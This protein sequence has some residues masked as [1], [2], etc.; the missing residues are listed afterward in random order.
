MVKE[1]LP[2]LME[3]SMRES[4]KMVTDTDREPSLHLKEISMKG[5]SG[6]GKDMVKETSLHQRGII[7]WVN[8]R[9][10]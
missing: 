1:L 10:V 7:M 9:T 6:R 3:E 5:N 4:G 2:F 8:G